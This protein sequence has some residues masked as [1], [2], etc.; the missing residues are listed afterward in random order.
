MR[1]LRTAASLACL[2]LAEGPAA[3]QHIALTDDATLP[4][5]DVAAVRPGGAGAPRADASPGRFLQ[6]NMPLMNAVLLAFDLPPNQLAS[7]L[8][9]LTREPFSIDARMPVN[10]S[11][12]DLRL[13]LRA[14]LIDRFKLR[15]HVETRDQ[16]GFALTMARRDGRLGPRL[17]PA[18]VDCRARMEALRRNEPVPPQPEGSRPCG[19]KNGPGLIDLSGMPLSSLAQ[20]IANAAG[21]PVVDRTGLAG[22]FDAEMQ[23]SPAT[24]GPLRAD[25][26]PVL[27]GG[28][29]P[30]LFTAVQEQLGLK[31]EPAKSAV[32]YVVID[33]IERPQPD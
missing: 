12:A 24:S 10:T 25:A 26:D 33:H 20:W 23:W 22:M 18:Q 1:T 14:L 11:A 21:R 19:I 4:R 6:E 17:R 9:D 13:M 2:L 16:D 5:F 3:A 32:D 30:S 29:G 7:P 8:P 31:L 15:V 28:D 27:P